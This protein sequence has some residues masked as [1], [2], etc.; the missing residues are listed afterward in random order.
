MQEVN[1]ANTPIDKGSAGP[2]HLSSPEI[3]SKLN[4]DAGYLVRLR[5]GG[6][7]LDAGSNVDTEISSLPTE[8]DPSSVEAALNYSKELRIKDW[9]RPDRQGVLPVEGKKMWKRD[10][11]AW[12][13]YMLDPTKFPPEAIKKHR[14]ALQAFNRSKTDDIAKYIDAFDQNYFTKDNAELKLKDLLND[15][16]DH[17]RDE[18][19]KVDIVSMNDEMQLVK[20]IFNWAG[21]N[22]FDDIA[23][24]YLNAIAVIDASDT[25][26][27]SKDGFYKAAE[28]TINDLRTEHEIKLVKLNNASARARKKATVP[29][30]SPGNGKD[31]D[32][33]YLPPWE[34]LELNAD[35]FADDEADSESISL[36]PGPHTPSKEL[37]GE[38]ES[39]AKALEQLLNGNS[40]IA[41]YIRYINEHSNLSQPTEIQNQIRDAKD[42]INAISQYALAQVFGVTDV[43][44]FRAALEEFQSDTKYNSL[45]YMHF[46]LTP[47]LSNPNDLISSFNDSF[48]EIRD[49]QDFM[50]FIRAK[51]LRIPSNIDDAL[52]TYLH[53]MD[54]EFDFKVLEFNSGWKR[55][56]AIPKQKATILGKPFAEQTL[57]DLEL[58]TKVFEINGKSEKFD[59]INYIPDRLEIQTSGPYEI[60]AGS[61]RGIERRDKMDEDNFAIVQVIDA[62]G[63]ET[64]E[65]LLI[66]ADGMGGLT[67]GAEASKI[68]VEALREKYTEI[69]IKEPQKSSAEA[70][71]EAVLYSNSQLSDHSQQDRAKMGSTCVAAVLRDDGSYVVANVGDS[72]AYRV[73]ATQIQQITTDHSFVARLVE[74]KVIQPE[75][76]YTHPERNRIYRNMGNKSNVEVD[77]FE[78]GQALQ[79]DEQLL[80]CCDGVW[81]MTKGSQVIR[82][83]AR[84][85]GDQK[86]VARRLIAKAMQEGGEDNIT[87]LV[88]KRTLGISEN[89]V[90][91]VPSDKQPS[92][93]ET[94]Q[95]DQQQ[96]IIANLTNRINNLRGTPEE[97]QVAQVLVE[98]VVTN[99]KITLEEILD[100]LRDKK[101]ADAVSVSL[102]GL[103]NRKK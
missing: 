13:E 86:E 44:A 87:V 50:S 85:T 91:Q 47:H 30:S 57:E 101:N 88:A 48:G 90:Q 10:F 4:Q 33:P 84:S 56:E 62:E 71:Q 75:D 64:G 92:T 42:K 20:N 24:D 51:G 99:N 103:E 12:A 68:V 102:K 66:L 96:V 55:Y 15:A 11:A 27:F 72:R 37:G 65:T 94:E 21:G 78:S 34:E 22:G 49:D 81:E 67:K 2:D 97:K 23:M 16:V 76:V 74:A 18:D 70:L 79:P 17:Y 28:L 60:G 77:I 25:N 95:P 59:L 80:L 98:R 63:K 29:S 61:D 54:G 32:P 73:N 82:K 6:D 8:I 26:G 31:D 14:N 58:G 3:V 5:L 38:N 39:L 52:R 9:E 83:F 35:L 93:I 40:Q 1:V 19:R 43:S 100:A 53:S 46:R 41:G 36:P 7:A 45:T 69:K 89:N